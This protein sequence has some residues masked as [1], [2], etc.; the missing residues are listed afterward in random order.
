MAA[1]LA[2]LSSLLW[3]S[4]DFAGGLLTRRL[5]AYAVVGASQACG[6]IAVSVVVVAAGTFADDLAWLPW[7]MAAGAAGS[8]ALVSFYAALASGTMGVVS[9]IAALGAVVPVVAGVASGEQPSL[10]AY[11][12]MALALAGAVAASAPELRGATG[13]RP[14][15]LAVLAGIGFGL[16][17]LFIARGAEHS[18]LMTLW[19]MRATSVTGF[20]LAAL[21]VRRIG[22]LAVRDLAPLVAIGLGDAGANL[23]FALASTRGLV[24]VTAVLGSLYPVVTVLLAGVF[25]HERLQRVQQAGVVAALVGVA[26][27]SLG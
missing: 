20:G 3:G 6:L 23:M 26:L 25:L 21:A 5:P 14:V 12:G 15:L 11:G 8:L 16:T 13:A 22:G 2:L 24:S 19:G 27:L 7:A 4:A 1:L 10:V 17:M 18:S 9:P